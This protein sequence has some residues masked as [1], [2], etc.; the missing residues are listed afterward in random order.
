MATS[1]LASALFRSSVRRRP[2]RSRSPARGGRAAPAPPRPAAR[3]AA[4]R[5]ARTCTPMRP[6]A[7]TTMTRCSALA[8]R[9]SPL[10]EHG[11]QTLAIGSADGREGQADL[12]AD[13]ARERQRGL[14]GIGLV[15][16]NKDVEERQQPVVELPSPAR[17]A[18]PPCA[19]QL[20]PARAG[21]R[22]SRSRCPPCPRWESI[23]SSEC[24]VA[25][26]HR[27][28]VR[29]QGDHVGD[30][31]EVAAGLLDADDV[32]VLGE[33]RDGLGRDVG[34]RAARDVVEHQ[35][36]ARRLGDGL[37]VGDDPLL[38][39]LVVVGREQERA[40]GA[41]LPGVARQLDGLV[42]VVGAGPATTGTR[43]AAAATTSSITRL[44]SAWE[45]VADSPVEPQGTSPSIPASICRLSTSASRAARP[46]AV[47]EGR[48]E[49]GQNSFEH[50]SVLLDV[51]RGMRPVKTS[52]AG[53]G[54]EHVRIVCPPTRCQLA[55]PQRDLDLPVD[56][57]PQHG[58]HRHR[59]G[60]AA[61]GE[62][63]PG[64]ALPGALADAACGPRSR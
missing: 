18:G 64:P 48:D 45:S 28:V 43:P 53:P 10:L 57:A 38:G 40:V 50:P 3:G 23:G 4:P 42:G 31:I 9:G 63:L 33:A 8:I 12:L 6:Q 16:Q 5:P 29:A 22:W 34:R 62:S 56:G 14:H 61:A 26:H 51:A 32:G 54:H 13:G 15:S 55:A 39:G 2:A 41:G 11:L 60:A 25:R 44:C 49:G 46:L 35:G 21:P 19:L 52:A 1:Q 17:V 7:P 47:A 20:A 59:A 24:V 37:V 30:L 27:E 36:E 58:A